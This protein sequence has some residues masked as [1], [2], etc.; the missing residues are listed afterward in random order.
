[1]FF[2]KHMSHLSEIFWEALEDIWS[3][4]GHLF[5]APFSSAYMITRASALAAAVHEKTQCLDNCIGILDGTVLGKARLGLHAAQNVVYNGHKRKH[6]LKF[7]ALTGP[8]GMFY[9]FFG[10]M[11]GH[12]HDWTLYTRSGLEEILSSALYVGGRQFCIYGDSGYIDAF[13]LK[14]HFKGTP[15]PLKDI[16]T[17][18]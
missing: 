11:E 4:F 17:N 16:L 10:P 9:H 7:Q 18:L 6:A 14:I 2:R 1:M 5:T 13:T 15:Q 12:R 3:S 8:D